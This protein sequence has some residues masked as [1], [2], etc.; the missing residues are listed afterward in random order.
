MSRYLD[1]NACQFHPGTPS[2]LTPTPACRYNG[3]PT[4]IDN[5]L[6]KR[7]IGCHCPSLQPS[8]RL[9]S[10]RTAVNRRADYTCKVVMMPLS[11]DTFSM[12][13]SDNVCP[14]ILIDYVKICAQ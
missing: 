13:K 3:A 9:A 14:L 2:T 10:E 7:L 5:T 1:I 12:F 8:S 6:P 4:T 11:G